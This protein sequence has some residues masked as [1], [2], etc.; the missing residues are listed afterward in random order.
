M[1]R[2]GVVGAGGR[3]GALITQGVLSQ[4]DMQLAGALETAAHPIVGRDPGL[5]LGGG[6]TGIT[7]T[8][9]R[10]EA[11]AEC[12]VIIDFSVPQATLEN[13]RYAAL[14]HKALVIGTTGMDEQQRRTIA[15]LAERTPM[16]MAPNMSIGVNVMFKVAGLVAR[17]LEDYDIEIVETHHR[18]KQD[19]P[20][21]TAIGLAE[22]VARA[23]GVSLAEHARYARHGI[24]GERPAGQIGI[25]SLR[26]GDVVGDHTVMF[27]G[28]GERIELTH[29][30][31][32]RANFAQGA[33]RAA[34]WV[35]SQ[36]PGLYTMLDVLGLEP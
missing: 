3:M 15:E 16:V 10:E 19:A 20:S 11:F 30:A 6:P 26:A 28:G 8:A 9:R 22:A 17:L 14:E 21:G 2:V 33:V 5:S 32:S 18:H 36:G 29:R 23:R 13:A 31:H 27:A 4:A 34:H 12:D 1:I 7:V 24:I 35:V 25:Q